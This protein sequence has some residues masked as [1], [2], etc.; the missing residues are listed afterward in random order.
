MPD[1]VSPTFNP[2]LP[3]AA[4]HHGKPAYWGYDA[5]QLPAPFNETF[6]DLVRQWFA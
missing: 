3:A 6:D 4:R 2:G 5:S 1:L